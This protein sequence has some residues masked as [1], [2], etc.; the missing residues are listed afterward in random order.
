[1]DKN[2]DIRGGGSQLNFNGLFTVPLEWVIIIN[3]LRS[4]YVDFSH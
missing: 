3:A 4:M 1:M 2:K